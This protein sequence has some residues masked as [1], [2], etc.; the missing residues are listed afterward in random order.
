MRF[1]LRP[2]SSVTSD[3]VTFTVRAW[4]GGRV[5][6][7]RQITVQPLL[8]VSTA[9]LERDVRRG[10]MLASG[11]FRD[12][13]QWLPPRTAELCA[14]PARAA[15]CAAARTLKAGDVL[16][17]LHLQRQTLIQR[18]DRVAVRCLVGGVV[19]SL[20]A[21]ARADGA[22]GETIAL[23]KLGER[24]EFTAT[25][26]GPGEAVVNLQGRRDDR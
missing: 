11:D 20:T 21:E 4:S 9:V 5:A 12:V 7:S 10:E 19:I 24:R 22:E 16:R 8:K 14:D 23:R 2:E 6:E 17:E 13:L 26:T 3:R 1:E 15:G 25:V 18:G